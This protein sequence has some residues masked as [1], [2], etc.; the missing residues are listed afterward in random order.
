MQILQKETAP[1]VRSSHPPID[2][3]LDLLSGE[4][5]EH[6]REALE[7]HC[8]IC[9]HCSQN[10]SRLRVSL[11]RV[12][13]HLHREVSRG[14]SFSTLYKMT[15]RN[16]RRV[17]SAGFRVSLAAVSAAAA[18]VSLSLAVPRLVRHYTTPVSR[19]VLGRSAPVALFALAAIGLAG[20]ILTVAAII[21]MRKH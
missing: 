3:L 6:V 11:G 10:L 15:R 2:M 4:L 7:A 21:Q 13:Q 8:L 5:S 1:R 9:S 12:E 16:N 20:C 19:E 17:Q 14:W 18:A